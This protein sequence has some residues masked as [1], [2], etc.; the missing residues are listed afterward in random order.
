MKIESN[1]K[2]RFKSARVFEIC[3]FL[4]LVGFTLMMAIKN[5]GTR[6]QGSNILP[7]Q[8]YKMHDLTYPV[9]DYDL[10]G[11]TSVQEGQPKMYNFCCKEII[12]CV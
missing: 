1:R 5:A 6:V 8:E 4:S 10:E 3:F 11:V 2:E 7:I 12:H 9:T